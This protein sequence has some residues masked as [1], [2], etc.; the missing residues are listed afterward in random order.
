MYNSLGSI[1]G[2][3]PF[4][5]RSLV[6]ALGFC[7]LAGCAEEADDDAD[8]FEDAGGSPVT[9][10][11]G[12]TPSAGYDASSYPSFDSGAQ[13][14]L[15]SGNLLYDASTGSPDSGAVR[16]DSGV[17]APDASD[18]FGGLAGG[19][20]GL[21]GLLGGGDGGAAPADAGTKADSGANGQCSNQI[22]I[23]VFDCWIFYGS[24]NYTACD[25][26]VCK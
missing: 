20:A 1:L 18:P 19:L 4:S 5:S 25:G 13:P 15:D 14:A 16:N 24:C 3:S 6:L 23:D 7:A 8:A 11:D 9:T 26:L 17:A 2:R 22:C 10:I 21:G 12:S